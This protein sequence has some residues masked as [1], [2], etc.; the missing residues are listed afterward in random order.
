MCSLEVNSY[1]YI[2][3]NAA[4]TIHEPGST[5]VLVYIGFVHFFRL[6]LL[7]LLLLGKSVAHR[8]E[9]EYKHDTRVTFSEFENCR[10]APYSY[11]HF[12]HWFSCWFWYPHRRSDGV[13]RPGDRW[14]NLQLDDHT[15]APVVYFF[16]NNRTDEHT[17]HV[18]KR[19]I[20]ILRT[21]GKKSWHE[22]TVYFRL[23]KS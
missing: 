20:Q 4:A 1:K 5:V 3:S 23:S 10:C 12:L 2:N 8:G 18:D 17:K 9:G 14:Y 13:F 21:W 7:Q 22:R 15:W 19:M 16:H 6:L 11:V